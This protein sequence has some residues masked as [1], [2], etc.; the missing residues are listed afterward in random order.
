[1]TS[2]PEAMGRGFGDLKKAASRDSTPEEG[3]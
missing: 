3:T 1:M 2:C